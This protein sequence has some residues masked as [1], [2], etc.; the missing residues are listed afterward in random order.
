M[1]NEGLL[2]ELKFN[3]THLDCCF[4]NQKALQVEVL[5]DLD[6]LNASFVDV[7][8]LSVGNLSLAAH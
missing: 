2:V 1:D 4:P 3:L 7:L 5:F 8:Q 6:Q